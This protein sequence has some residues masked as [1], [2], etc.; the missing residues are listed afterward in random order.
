MRHGA[1]ADRRRAAPGR[2]EKRVAAIT[3]EPAPDARVHQGAGRVAV[4]A[5]GTV[6]AER[7]VAESQAHVQTRRI[8]CRCGDRP[9]RA[10]ADEL[11]AGAG[12][13]PP[14][15]AAS[16]GLVVLEE[17]IGDRG[18]ADIVQAAAERVAD[19]AV[20]AGAGVARAAEGP[21]ARDGASGQAEGGPVGI[22]DA[23]AAGRANEA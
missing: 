8:L 9:A 3:G 15:A 17:A 20:S 21:V 2:G 11:E 6:V 13:V 10:R 16:V 18:R 1:I 14:V 4:A 19:V 5:D 12:A 23:G 22:E 7:H